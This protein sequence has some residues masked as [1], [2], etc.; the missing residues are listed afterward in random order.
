MRRVLYFLAMNMAIL[1]MASIFMQVVLPLFGIY[2]QGHTAMLIF[3]FFFGMGGSF[4]SLA[5]SKRMAKMA[6]GAKVIENPQYP[7]EKWLVQTVERLAK[8]ANIGMPEVAVFDSPQ[9]NAFAT[10]AGK[11]SSLVAVS[12]GLMNA[13]DQGEAEAVLAHEVSHIANGDMV[14]MA[15]LQ[16]VLNTFVMFFARIV[17]GAIANARGEQ[18]GFFARMAIIFVMEMIFG[19][20]ANLIAMWFSRQREFRADEG[21]A[22]LVGPQ[23]MI[24][25]LERLK[26]G[27]PAEME[28]T[29]A[30]FGIN[31]KRASL[32]ASHPSLEDRIARLKNFG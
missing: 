26:A 25:A 5:L 2:P 24:A 16:G 19:F 7:A 20:F 11:N 22:R 3:C 4:I 1:I 29:L 8:D 15:L 9:V 14:T 28:G 18:M 27:Q 17:A 31:G 32:L 23:K 30:A 21:A 10:G 13:M 6:T 12:T